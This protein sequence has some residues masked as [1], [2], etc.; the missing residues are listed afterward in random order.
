MGSV[1]RTT[2]VLAAVSLLAALS[3]AQDGAAGSSG[4]LLLLTW[5]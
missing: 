5:R 3:G 1:S 4:K 2:I